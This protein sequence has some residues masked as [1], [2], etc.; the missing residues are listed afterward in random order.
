MI[1]P[2]TD[3]GRRMRRA[4]IRGAAFIAGGCQYLGR[5]HTSELL[6]RY[7]LTLAPADDLQRIALLNRL[8][9]V[10]KTNGRYDAAEICYVRVQAA[11]EASPAPR[12]G[13]RAVLHHNLAGLAYA[14]GEYQ[15][16]EREIR[17][18]LAINERP[19]VDRAADNGLL[20]AVLAAQFRLD[21]ARAVLRRTLVEM[22]AIHGPS[23]YEVA[24][25]LQN[26]AALDVRTDPERSEELYERALRIKRNRLGRTHPE[27]GVLL[28]NFATLHSQQQRHELA[29]AACR[30]GRDILRKRYGIDHP[31]TRTC[32]QNYLTISARTA[33]A[34]R[35]GLSS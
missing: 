12:P 7:A 2:T 16:A 13:D 5:L 18:A 21:D 28:N 8:G 20:G 6:L 11:L 4:A 29:V 30:Q 3:R 19:P 9:V 25:V 15:S 17:A 24:V 22:E 34:D 1:I 27:V 23:H 35:N 10:L 32:D 31:A 26:L 14:R 33:R